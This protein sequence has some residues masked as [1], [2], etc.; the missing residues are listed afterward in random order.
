MAELMPESFP[1]VEL[2]TEKQNAWMVG[3]NFYSRIP[4]SSWKLRR[5][6]MGEDNKIRMRPSNLRLIGFAEIRGP[7]ESMVRK[8][9]KSQINHRVVA[10][11]VVE[12][13]VSEDIISEGAT[14]GELLDYLRNSCYKGTHEKE[15][16]ETD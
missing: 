13:L 15:N 3:K 9:P 6:Y 8:P 1:A 10:R 5:V 12:E 4:G 14:V 16:R 11:N 2:L 7:V